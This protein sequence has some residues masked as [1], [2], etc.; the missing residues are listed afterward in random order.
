MNLLPHKTET[1]VVACSQ[2]EFLSS[3]QKAT[4]KNIRFQ[5]ADKNHEQLFVGWIQRNKFRISLKLNRPN[6]FV[7]L[8]IGQ[9]EATSSGCIIFVKFTLFPFTRMHLI[10]WTMF[11]LIMGV[12]LFFQYKSYLLLLAATCIM[13]LIHWIA[14]ANFSLQLKHTRKRLLKVIA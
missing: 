11:V 5:N 3:L 9:C 12:I 4:S 14:W 1:F 8:V 7:P 13:G 2:R 10:F 6:N